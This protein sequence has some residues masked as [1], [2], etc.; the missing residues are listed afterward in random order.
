[1][2]MESDTEVVRSRTRWMATGMGL[3]VAVALL[4]INEQ[5]ERPNQAA[6]TFLAALAVF[7]GIMI[8]KTRVQS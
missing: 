7:S 1:M 8:D 6:A 3:L 4:G 5:L 2:T